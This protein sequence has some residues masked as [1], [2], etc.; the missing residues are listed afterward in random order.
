[1][2]IQIQMQINQAIISNIKKE[3]HGK[4]H[5]TLGIL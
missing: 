4:I 2:K 5:V 3:K 1:M